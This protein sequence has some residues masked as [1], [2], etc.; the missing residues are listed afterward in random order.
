VEVNVLADDEIGNSSEVAD[1]LVN[2]GG[3]EGIA[4]VNSGTEN[5]DGSGLF[6]DSTTYSSITPDNGNA[7]SSQEYDSGWVSLIE[8]DVTLV[9]GPSSNKLVPNST[10]GFNN[11][12]ALVNSNGSTTTNS[13]TLEFDNSGFTDSTVEF[14]SSAPS[15]VTV[16]GNASREYTIDVTTGST[17]NDTGGTLSIT[18]N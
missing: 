13:H 5:T 16:D 2:V 10:V 15:G 12:I 3:Y 1:V 14:S 6:P 7:S 4:V 9:F 18:I 11:L 17:S 8:N